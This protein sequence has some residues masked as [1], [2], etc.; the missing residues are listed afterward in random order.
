MAKPSKKHL[1]SI[2]AQQIQLQWTH[3]I[4]KSKISSKVSGLTKNY[5]ITINM[6]KISS[7]H[8]II[9]E[10]HL[11]LRSHDLKG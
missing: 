3:S 5:C 7:I 10:I 11:I 4:Q 1:R 6:Q 8:K 9:L 2:H